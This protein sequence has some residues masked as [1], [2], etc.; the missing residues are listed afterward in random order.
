MSLSTLPVFYVD[1]FTNTQFQGNPAAVVLLD[2]WLPD[3]QLIA[4]AAEI[5]LSETAFLVGDHIRWLDRK[6]VV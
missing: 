4:I 6:S 2:E 5:N 1:A 3:N